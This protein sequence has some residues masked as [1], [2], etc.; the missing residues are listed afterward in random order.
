M[1]TATKTTTAKKAAK[2][3]PAQQS[4]A[5]VEV[6]ADVAYPMIVTTTARQVL[7]RVGMLVDG[8]IVLKNMPEPAYQRG[9]QPFTLK[10]KGEYLAHVLA[11]GAFDS[12]SVW[13]DEPDRIKEVLDGRQRLHCLA[14]AVEALLAREVDGECEI[15][16]NVD[17]AISAVL[18]SGRKLATLETVLDQAPWF[19]MYHPSG[20][21][22]QDRVALFL[23]LNSGITVAVKHKADVAQQET[24][25]LLAAAG[26]RMATT[27]AGKIKASEAQPGEKHVYAS[28]TVLEA[29][30][31]YVRMHTDETISKLTDHNANIKLLAEIADRQDTVLSDLNWILYTLMPLLH[32]RYDNTTDGMGWNQVKIDSVTVIGGIAAG[33]GFARMDKTPK[34]VDANRKALVAL[35]SK[36]VDP[37][38]I[39]GSQGLKGLYDAPTNNGKKRRQ[40]VAEGFK[41]FFREGAADEDTP[42]KWNLAAASAAIS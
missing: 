2:A 41:A 42:I 37:L 35:V 36:G 20:L 25:E 32:T 17:K 30:N 7:T 19:V 31:S 11:G 18:E 16:S 39:N 21:S 5:S 1:T 34:T 15:N 6:I 14:L 12:V 33:L 22:Y 13:T 3:V 29:F 4:A 9:N 10:Q 24:L 27:K 8:K 38:N 28:A 26:I 40:L 23:V